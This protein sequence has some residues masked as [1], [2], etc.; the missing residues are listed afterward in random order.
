MALGNHATIFYEFS[1]RQKALLSRKLVQAHM[2]C[3]PSD[4]PSDIYSSEALVLE[5]LT[6]AWWV[7]MEFLEQLI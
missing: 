4:S 1:G 2:A 3:A 6:E 5:P 7:R